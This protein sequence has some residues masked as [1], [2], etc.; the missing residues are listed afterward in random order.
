MSLCLE[1]EGPGANALPAPPSPH[2]LPC[3]DEARG[4]TRAGLDAAAPYLIGQPAHQCPCWH[5]RTHPPLA[6]PTPAKP[7][8]AGRTRIYRNDCAPGPWLLRA[9]PCLGRA[10][11]GAWARQATARI[12]PPSRP[13]LLNARLAGGPLGARLELGWVA[14]SAVVAAGSTSLPACGLPACLVPRRLS[15]NASCLASLRTQA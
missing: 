4:A 12:P 10:S 2:K 9:P 11:S 1:T 3:D 5:M 8:E 15:V 7:K 14:S 13:W 6:A